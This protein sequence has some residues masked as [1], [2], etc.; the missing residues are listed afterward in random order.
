MN[1]RFD[2]IASIVFFA[3]GILVVVE[4]QKISTSAYGSSVGPSAF[5]IGLGI[6]LI[7]LSIFLFIETV[8]HKK[9][10]E[11]AASKNGES[12]PNY[13]NFLIIFISALA[14]VLLLEPVGYLITTFAFLL[15]AFQTLEK[16]KF[17]TSAIIAAGFTGVIYFGF[18]NVLGGSLPG[19]P[20]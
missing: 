18:V 5:P 7:V 19:L 10:Y 6:L 12:A 17:I 9:A 13:K 14:Y 15:I 20:F 11:I 3:L 16:G 8:R 1:I 2:R 4:S